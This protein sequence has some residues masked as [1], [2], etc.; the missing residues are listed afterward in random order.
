MAARRR[1][2]LTGKSHHVRSRD[3]GPPPGAVRFTPDGGSLIAY[4]QRQN[5]LGIV[6][7]AEL[8]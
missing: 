4:V 8:R 5:T 2:A 3:A 6:A 1:H 7:A